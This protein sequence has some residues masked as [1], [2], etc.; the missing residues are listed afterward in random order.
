MVLPAPAS[1]SPPSNPT[2]LLQPVAP[3]SADVADHPPLA[4]GLFGGL[5]AVSPD[6]KFLALSVSAPGDSTRWLQVIDLD[7][8]LPVPLPDHTGG[9]TLEPVLRWLGW[10]PDDRHVYAVG[11][12][13]PGGE[14]WDVD[15]LQ[16][17]ARRLATLDYERPWAS[18]RVSADGATVYLFG[19]R[20]FD[21]GGDIAAGVP[22][23]EAI[24]ARTGAVRGEVDLA[25]VHVWGSMQEVP[26]GSRPY[27][28]VPV[29]GV[30]MSPDGSLLYVVH[31]DADRVTVVD[32]LSL[33]V[34]RTVE[35]AR[36]Q[37]TLARAGGWLR[38][39]FAQRAE[40]KGGVYRS[41]RA[42]VSP[43]GHRLY[44]TGTADLTC[45]GQPTFPCVEGN[46]IGL[47]VVDLQ[48]MRIV[49]EIP[50]FST[51][52]TSPDGRW[53]VG[54]GDAADYRHPAADG[55]GTMIGFGA[56]IIDTSS[57]CV[58]RVA[59]G[60]PFTQVAVS[61]DGRFAYLVSQVPG[62]EAKPSL[63][64]VE[65]ATGKV[66]GRRAIDGGWITLIGLEPGTT[67]W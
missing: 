8:W 36:S 38:D 33:T 65:L 67:A 9:G 31:G 57:W 19:A 47:E 16:G 53:L 50:G 23:V 5:H 56:T 15:L 10:G 62:D 18:P 49:R 21:A 41:K 45:A 55:S 58:A 40:A 2:Q 30:A 61:R 54:Y 46:P 26:P 14:L 1:S 63:T 43:D 44:V 34:E 11:G 6:G 39:R 13:L 25:S 32:L 59:P 48:S 52:A 7:T 35:L 37:S 17:T 64:V 24:D 60:V 51:L 3:S 4:I 20:S 27:A 29:P 12:N 28:V 22:F 42:L 66:S